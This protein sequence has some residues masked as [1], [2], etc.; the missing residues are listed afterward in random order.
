M[1]SPGVNANASLVLNGDF[2]E[3]LSHW[4]K[5]PTNQNWVM[6]AGEPYN[7]SEIKMLTAGHQGSA[8]QEV[9]IP[10]T[11][12]TGARYALSFLCENRAYANAQLIIGT[13]TQPQLKVIDLPAA[14]PENR[15]RNRQRIENGQPL[16]FKPLEYDIALDDLP[17]QERETLRV[18]VQSP[19]NAASDDYHLKVC[20]T[21]IN[22]SLHLAPLVVQAIVLDQ[23][24]VA[25]DGPV[26]LCLGADGG[27]NHQLSCV[28]EA[29]SPWAGTPAALTSHDNPQ[30]AIGVTPDWGVDH[31]LGSESAWIMRCPLIGDQ[32]LW[33]FTMNLVNRF[34]ADP[35]PIAVSLGHHRL[36]FR[37]VLEA[38]YYPVLGQSVRLGVQVASWYTGFVLENRAVTWRVEGQPDTVMAMTDPDGWAYFDYRPDTAGDFIVE[39]SVVSPYYASGVVTSKLD[40][41]V[42]ATDPWD[43]VMA[44]VADKPEPWALKTGWPNRG[45]IMICG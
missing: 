20:I 7:G 28:P 9:V 2:T 15:Q 24:V 26:Y 11:A 32:E 6:V 39:A 31:P 4:R 37:D 13:A 1:S 44:I 18:T 22:L 23:E 21:R 40:V 3:S 19:R 43:E 36:I 17:F 29:G 30:G 5:G 8:F 14:T 41:R 27:F 38:D 45:G 10:V 33:L 34:T 16:E 35:Y 42:L 25:P 12:G